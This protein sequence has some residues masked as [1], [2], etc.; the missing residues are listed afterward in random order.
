[1]LNFY[2]HGMTLRQ[3]VGVSNP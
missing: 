2:C 3:G 1:L